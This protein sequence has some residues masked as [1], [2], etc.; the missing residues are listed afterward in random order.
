MADECSPSSRSLGHVR[1]I[2]AVYTGQN[3]QRNNASLF[4]MS[5]HRLPTVD[6]LSLSRLRAV[7]STCS[8]HGKAVVTLNAGGDELEFSLV[9]T[10]DSILSSQNLAWKSG[11]PQSWERVITL[12]VSACQLLRDIPES[13]FKELPFLENVV[14]ENCHNVTLVGKEAFYKCPNL[15]HVSFNGSPVTTVDERAFALCGALSGDVFKSLV[16]LTT[17]CDGAFFRCGNLKTGVNDSLE[18]QHSPQLQSV[19]VAAFFGIDSIANVSFANCTKLQSIA[20]GAFSCC[21]KLKTVV[22]KDSPDV[23]VEPG[24][25]SPIS[26]SS[27][28]N[29]VEKTVLVHIKNAMQLL[30]IFGQVEPAND[31]VDAVN[32][33]IERLRTEVTARLSFERPK[34]NVAEMD[35]DLVKCTLTTIDNTRRT[36]LSAASDASPYAFWPA[37]KLVKLNVLGVAPASDQTNIS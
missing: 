11:T 27:G 3:E 28:L 31:A 22:I 6:Q 12:N 19:G 16:D 15:K 10:W 36:Q 21:G 23:V 4:L 32:D 20:R 9:D 29:P 30:Q 5:S 1:K 24:A 33:E 2:R 18:F 26:Y 25:F 7:L 14:I 8:T 17:I 37:C 34:R 35:M 13:C